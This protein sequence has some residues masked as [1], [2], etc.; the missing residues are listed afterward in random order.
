MVASAPPRRVDVIEAFIGR[1]RIANRAALGLGAVV[2]VT[3]MAASA[4]GEE[5]QSP[6]ARDAEIAQAEALHRQ[7]RYRDAER[8]LTG[9]R[10]RDDLSAPQRARVLMRLAAAQVELG[11]H[12]EALRTADEAQVSATEAGASELLIRLEIVRGSA[13]WQQGFP[14]RGRDHYAEGLK[15]AEQIRHD[16]LR[17][18]VLNQLSNIHQELGDWG[19]VLDYAER[20]FEANPNPSDDQRFLY[21]VNRGIAFYEFHDRDR[22]EQSFRQAL[23]IATRTGARRSQSFALGELG[24]VAWEFDRDRERA[25]EHHDRAAAI[26][27]EIGVRVLEATWLNNAGNVFRDSG[28][29]TEALARYRRALELE[30]QGG[31]VRQ[32]VH[33]KNIGQ[34]L[35]T[36]GRTN[37][38]E[39]FLLK[40]LAAADEQGNARIRWQARMELGDVYRRTDPA[41]AEQY[42]TE[43]LDVLEANQSSALLEGFRAGVLGRALDQYDPYDRY[44]RFLMERGDASAAF[45][46]AERARARVFL[47]TLTVARDELAAKVPPAYL[48]AETSLLQRIS[49]RQRRLR[50]PGLPA[51]ERRTLTADIDAAEDELRA[52]RLRL[53][54]DRPSLADTRFPRVWSLDEVRQQLLAADEA[55]VMFFLGRQQSWAW[56]VDPRRTEV[57]QLPARGE[58]ERMVRGLLP[59]L[60]SPDAAVDTTAREWLSRTLVAPVLARVPEQAHLVIAP[61]AILAYLP[62]EVLADER[63]RYLVERNPISYAP[64]VSSFAFLRQRARTAPQHP[65]LVAIGSPSGFTAGRA[66]ERAASVEWVGLLKPLPYSGVELERVADLFEPQVQVLSGPA[67]TEDALRAAALDQAAILHFATH[68]LIDEERPE[69]SGLALSPGGAA[70]GILQTREIYRFDLNAALVTLSACQTALGRDVTG[71]G[72]VGMSRAFFYAGANA[73]TASLWNVS[74]RTTADLMAAFYDA[75]RAGTPIDRALA[76]AKRSFLRGAPD[77]RHPYYWAPFI[78][79]GQARTAMIF[80]AASIAR[81]TLIGV[82]AVVAIVVAV[83]VIRRR[84]RKIAPAHA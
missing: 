24:L 62:F 19:R 20:A 8:A 27:R 40:A 33:F 66:D 4:A 61:H 81:P 52:L 70:D 45:T 5:S 83:I 12:D 7:S 84:R 25:L 2:L 14:A 10:A 9:L 48:Q 53:A 41:R 43:S 46:I 16:A 32:T 65:T 80:P 73:V 1:P 60:Q 77:R 31:G 76:E 36:L 75:I 37:E 42:F 44:I 68:A 63:G 38:A 58:I 17:G 47:E 82:S 23:E 11:R 50:E 57:V 59:T 34:V 22:A 6:A 69:R 26:A 56:I 39:G 29:P 72:L 15:L 13:W 54:V 74:D 49:A 18:E 51:D 64:S 30:A 35:S 21:H 55:L 3:M 79:M 78:V 71:E 67:A 28:E